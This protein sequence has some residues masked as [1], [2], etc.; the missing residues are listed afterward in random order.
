MNPR[1][2]L[3]AAL[4]LAAEPSVAQHK[5]PTE[6]QCRQMVDTMVQMVK[7]GETRTEKDKRDA[8]ALAERVEK[9]VKD[10]RARGASECDSW[11]AIGKLAVN[12]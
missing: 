5:Q 9:I 4:V 11:R 8:Q 10:N 6:A 1:F 12:Q 7:S 3:L 2:A